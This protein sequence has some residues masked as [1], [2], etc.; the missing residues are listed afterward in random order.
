MPIRYWYIHRISFAIWTLYGSLSTPTFFVFIFK[1]ENS[2]NNFVDDHQNW[3]KIAPSCILFQ[4]KSEIKFETTFEIQ[5]WTIFSKNKL[6]LIIYHVVNSKF[7]NHWSSHHISTMTSIEHEIYVFQ[8]S[9]N[10]LKLFNNIP[11]LKI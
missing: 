3:A 10:V 9:T 5:I 4:Q 1:I 11:N 8:L 6:Q 7:D 2:N